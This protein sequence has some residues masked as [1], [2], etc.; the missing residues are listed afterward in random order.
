MKKHLILGVLIVLL[1]CTLICGQ[2]KPEKFHLEL[3]CGS[4]LIDP[5]DLN[6]RA[7]TDEEIQNFY[8][9]DY[10]SHISQQGTLFRYSKTRA[11]ANP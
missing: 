6:L 8:S 3:I 10:D 5:A 2:E 7:R 11:D 1:A 9:D 4:S